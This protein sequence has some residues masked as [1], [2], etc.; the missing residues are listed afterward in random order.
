MD[1]F[2]FVHRHFLKMMYQ[3]SP[4][5]TTTQTHNHMVWINNHIHLFCRKLFLIA[6][7][8]KVS[9]DLITLCQQSIRHGKRL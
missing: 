5:D 8:H 2:Q 9:L 4:F 1:K 3:H 7:C 6:L